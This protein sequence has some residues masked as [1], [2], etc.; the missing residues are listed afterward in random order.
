ME[1]DRIKLALHTR[2][3]SI[4]MALNSN[5]K[6]FLE[7]CR[8]SEQPHNNHLHNENS[9]APNLQMRLSTEKVLCNINELLKLIKELKTMVLLYDSSD[10]INSTF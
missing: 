10:I 7:A 8:I 9:V 1:E 5:L 2:L 6:S 4:V 3:D